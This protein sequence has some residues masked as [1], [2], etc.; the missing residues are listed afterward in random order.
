MD[1]LDREKFLALNVDM[2]IHHL[3]S[4]MKMME[5]EWDDV[6]T[7]Q[8]LIVYI[9]EF[10]VLLPKT[11]KKFLMLS[12]LADKFAIDMSYKH[13]LALF[14]PIERYY[15]SSVVDHEFLVTRK[16]RPSKSPSKAFSR[17]LLYVVLDNIRSAFNVGSILRTSECFAVDKVYLCGYTATPE[18]HKVKLTAMGTDE[19]LDWEWNP[20]IEELIEEL[21]SKKIK[22]IAMETVENSTPYTEIELREPT[23]VILGNEKHGLS[24]KVLSLSDEISHIPLLGRKNSL[25]VS[26][27]F[28]IFISNLLI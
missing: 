14:T 23:A 9:K 3:F 5:K 19:Y 24:K 25:N 18:H 11:D 26:N 12:S 21:K 2:K 28:S 13:Y 8:S 4:V 20:H 1:L 16:D 15:H 10:L 22:I 27:S 6:I 7:R 17:P